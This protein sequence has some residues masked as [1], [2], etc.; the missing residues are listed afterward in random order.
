MR[1]FRPGGYLDADSMS[2]AVVGLQK[3]RIAGAQRRLDE[4]GRLANIS[5][6]ADATIAVRNHH[7]RRLAGIMRNRKWL[8]FEITD[9]EWI[10]RIKSAQCTAVP[11]RLGRGE[12]AKCQP[13]GISNRRAR[14]GTPPT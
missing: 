5:Q 4:A 11:P 10:V 8:H 13:T 1:A 12:R 3:Q 7:L 9:G 2:S 6:H 14:R